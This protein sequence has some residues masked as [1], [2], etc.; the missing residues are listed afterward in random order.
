MKVETEFGPLYFPLPDGWVM[1]H[2]MVDHNVIL[3]SGVWRLTFPYY[4][5]TAGVLLKGTV[6]VQ[7]AGYGRLWNPKRALCE[8]A[9]GWQRN[10]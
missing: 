7:R 4:G 9:E 6:L 8:L 2:N 1:R 10:S 3:S 5:Y